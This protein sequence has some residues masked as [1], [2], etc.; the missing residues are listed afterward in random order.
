MVA[1]NLRCTRCL[2]TLGRI[3]A[4]WD[5]L[6]DTARLA[7]LIVDAPVRPGPEAVRRLPLMPV[8]W[9]RDGVWRRRWGHRLYGE[10]I[11]FDAA[12][13]HLGTLA[14]EDALDALGTASRDDQ[15]PAHR[16]KGGT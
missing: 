1:V 15:A 7:V 13:R 11:R 2:A 6:H 4:E 16:K 12:G 9:D 3:A 5:E 10:L 8:W 14:A